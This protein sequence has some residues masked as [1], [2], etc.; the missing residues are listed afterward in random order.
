LN[1]TFRLDASRCLMITCLK[2]L[3][4][5]KRFGGKKETNNLNKQDQSKSYFGA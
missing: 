4:Y 3:I 5:G 2:R 1:E